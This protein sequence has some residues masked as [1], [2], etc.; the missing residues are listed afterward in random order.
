MMLTAQ[1]LHGLSGTINERA[2]NLAELISKCITATTEHSRPSAV[3]LVV[4]IARNKE[5]PHL[6]EVIMQ[7]KIKSPKTKFSDLTAWDEAETV[8]AFRTDEE[9]GQQIITGD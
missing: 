5:D 4:K 3:N 2:D 1:Q 7:H 6:I 8:R 9:A